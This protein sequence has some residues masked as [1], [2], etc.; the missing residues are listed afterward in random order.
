MIQVRKTKDYKREQSS[1]NN[2]G[3]DSGRA[4]LYYYFKLDY[5]Q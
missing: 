3:I 1:P 5:Y 2:T 4:C